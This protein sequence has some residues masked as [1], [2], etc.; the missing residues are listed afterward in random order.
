MKNKKVQKKEYIQEELTDT[1][2]LGALS[3]S[4]TMIF[5]EAATEIINYYKNMTRLTREIKTD[6][7]TKIDQVLTKKLR[8]I[9]GDQTIEVLEAKLPNKEANAFNL[10]TPHLFYTTELKKELKSERELIA[11]LLHE[12]AHYKMKH[13]QKMVVGS[14]LLGSTFKMTLLSLGNIFFISTGM[15]Y[16]TIP[17]NILFRIISFV[18]P[19]NSA[20]M[21]LT[22]MFSH[23][24]EFKSDEFTKKYGYDKE[25]VAVFKRWDLKTR[26]KICAKIKD[27]DMCEKAI[28]SMHKYVEHPSFGDRVDRLSNYLLTN[29][30]KLKPSGNNSAKMFTRKWRHVRDG[31]L[32]KG[33]D[34][35]K[36]GFAF[37]KNTE[38]E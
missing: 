7:T 12:Y 24:Q 10:A 19:K 30:M 6:K 16:M 17:F 2:L 36:Y 5:F 22:Y 3:A 1:F 11:I 8:D 21:I 29:M 23:S 4:V 32:A 13:S 26:R 28:R 37:L 34:L 14:I 38:E 27:K 33:A 18:I 20:N 9:T 15:L 35:K 25:L 31:V